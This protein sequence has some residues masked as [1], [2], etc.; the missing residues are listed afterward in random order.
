[1]VDVK[2]TKPTNLQ[3]EDAMAHYQITLD[4]QT[5]PARVEQKD[6]ALAQ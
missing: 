2:A 4:A 1:L 5:I 6:Q 3:E